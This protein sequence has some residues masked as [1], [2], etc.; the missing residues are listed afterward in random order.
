MLNKL[1]DEITK[2][3]AVFILSLMLAANGTVMYLGK[4]AISDQNEA[5]NSY[6]KTLSGLEIKINSVEKMAIEMRASSFKDKVRNLSKQ[7]FKILKDPDDI[8]PIDIQA[9]ADFC[10]SQIFR[11]Y[12]PT[13]RGSDLAWIKRACKD[14]SEWL[15][16]NN[17][18]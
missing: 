13:I 10:G 2:R 15:A 6:E 8:K 17:V 1:L 5:T 7:S 3:A 18:R 4:A 9:A 14:T 16:S 11:D 12:T